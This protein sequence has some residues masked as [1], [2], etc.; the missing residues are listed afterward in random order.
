MQKDYDLCVIGLGYIGLPT[1]ILSAAHGLNVLG[2][3][4]NSEIVKKV[5]EGKVHIV[6]PGLE[7]LCKQVV[8]DGRFFAGLTAAS[9][10]IYMI[11]VPTP[12]KENKIPDISF[13]EAAI[14]SVACWLKPDD[15]VI[16]ESTC[17][18]G[19][20]EK[21]LDLILALRND[22]TD[23][24]FMAYCPERVLPGDVVYELQENDRVIGGINSL[25]C[26]RAAQY[27]ST[28][29]KGEL[30]F[31]D[32]RTAEMCKLTENASRDIQIAF[33]NELSI[34]CDKAN[35]NVW[36][37]IQLANKHPRVNILRPGC[38]VGGH[39]IAVDPWFLVS[40]F[41]AET[42]LIA[43][44]RNLNLFKTSWCFSK[45]IECAENFRNINGRDALIGIMGLTFKE[46]IND[47]RES[48]ALEI[49]HKVTKALGADSVLCVEP[50]VEKIH[51]LQLADL[52]ETCNKCDVLVF[53]VR[54]NEFSDLK[55]KRDKT[56]LNFVGLNIRFFD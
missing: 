22:L 43:T 44:S 15:L 28:F 47:V 53:L 20:T 41:P 27:Y 24:I 31:T 26:E 13:V 40:D 10:K 56:I 17:P 18:V 45:I 6:E 46:N 51:G 25:S 5:N 3:D 50:N 38:G 36:D 49:A 33:A 23:K 39:C 37:L 11:V 21:M 32:M 35:I 52:N 14:R 2:V 1:A 16:I 55:L 34:I 19:T 42:H 9:S 4:I 12:F 8:H 54:H 29:V 7:T 30:H 48:P